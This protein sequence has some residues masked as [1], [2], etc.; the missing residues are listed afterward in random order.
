MKLALD[1]EAR[2]L[3]ASLPRCLPASTCCPAEGPG[4]DHCVDYG[5]VASSEHSSTAPGGLPESRGRP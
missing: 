5:I 3:S 4:G 2:S 1:V